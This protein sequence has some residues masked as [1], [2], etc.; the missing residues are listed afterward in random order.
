MIYNDYKGSNFVFY[1]LVQFLKYQ[2]LNNNVCLL[3][4]K[5]FSFSFYFFKL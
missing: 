4:E 3:V 5:E 1:F 2:F